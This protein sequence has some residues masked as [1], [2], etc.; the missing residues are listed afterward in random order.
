MRSVEIVKTSICQIGSLYIERAREEGIGEEDDVLTY[1]S[2]LHIYPLP[3]ATYAPRIRHESV[4]KFRY[5]PGKSGPRR[6]WE[7]RPLATE[8]VAPVQTGRAAIGSPRWAPTSR[9]VFDDRTAGGCRM[10]V[11]P[12]GRTRATTAPPRAI[13]PRR[14][15]GKPTTARRPK[16]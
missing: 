2:L 1:L 12:D 3:C 8:F 13:S 10:P 5:F 9:P 7:Q 4:R 11:A 16:P 15:I 14:P 6:P